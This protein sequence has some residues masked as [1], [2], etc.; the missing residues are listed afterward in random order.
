M[1]VKSVQFTVATHIAAVL[2]YF[3]DEEIS[4]GD[5]GRWTSWSHLH[6]IEPCIKGNM[7]I[8]KGTL[9]RRCCEGVSR[10]R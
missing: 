2:G 5:P 9:R 10:E 6:I 3:G 8:A 4:S 1:A 7:L